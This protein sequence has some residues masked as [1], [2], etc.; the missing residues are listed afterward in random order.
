MNPGLF[1]AAVV[2]ILLLA[3]LIA[4]FFQPGLRMAYWIYR[5]QKA[6]ESRDYDTAE[7]Y[8]QKL[9]R[10]RTRLRDPAQQAAVEFV[11]EHGLGLC[12][13]ARD[14]FPA[15]ERH[16]VR[17]VALWE[18]GVECERGVVAHM[19]A[20]LAVAQRA[21]G[22]T[23][24][25]E[26]TMHRLREVC[27]AAEE[28]EVH[29]VAELVIGAAHGA[30]FRN[31][32]NLAFEMARL[33]QSVLERTE[34]WHDGALAHTQIALASFH[35]MHCEYGPAR[36]LI[37]SAVASAGDELDRSEEHQA[38][39]TL[40]WID[41]LSGNLN[42]AKQAFKRSYEIQSADDGQEHWR[43]SIATA[44]LADVHRIA[45]EYHKAKEFSD[46]AWR[47]QSDQLPADDAIRAGT[48]VN[49]AMLL[50]DFGDFEEA[51]RILANAAQIADRRARRP[52]LAGIRLV[53]G[54][55]AF[56]RARY[57]RS[58][59]LLH[60]ARDIAEEI[61]GEGHR[62][63]CDYRAIL[64]ANLIRLSR[65]RE[66]ESILTDTLAIRE[67]LTDTSVIDLADLLCI[68]AE[69]YLET[70]RL[71]DSESAVLRAQNM[72]EGR[73]AADHLIH[74]EISETLGRIRHARSEFEAAIEHFRHAL[75]LRGK[76]QRP[77][78]PRLAKLLEA[79]AR[80]LASLGEA[81][82]AHE[83]RVRAGEI[84]KLY[85]ESD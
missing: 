77:D 64:G 7:S 81:E 79:S 19:L 11:A 14:E 80:S 42:A 82:K 55:S 62:M 44:A 47:I 6:L 46:T 18:Q 37:E 61:Y 9:S 43:T 66:A 10:I 32:K 85:Q 78:H 56:K 71:S 50:I 17:A 1:I 3:G 34:D 57:L 67:S 69:L 30:S 15:S 68:L 48:A 24:E 65:Y 35:M 41:T 16:L 22:Q 73:V 5:A 20:E 29:Q 53:Q 52:L 59:A 63:T 60:E 28:S 31:D 51:D 33:A 49:R 83:Q 58:D 40:G 75:N 54:V 4:Y 76:V 8:Y 27:E 39:F 21:Q 45:G 72:I 26:R 74:A 12:I 84:R 70:D 2:I 38:Y 23:A 36:E 13:Q 25:F